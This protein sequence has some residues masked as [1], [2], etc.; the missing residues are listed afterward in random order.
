MK[1]LLL[2]LLAC[3]MFILV[4]GTASFAQQKIGHINTQE[5]LQLMPER[6]SAEKIFVKFNAE[7]TKNYESMNV[8]YN[9]LVETYTKQKDSLS[10]FIRSAK[11]AELVDMQTKIQNFQTVAQQELVKKQNELM[12]PI[13]TK[14]KNA[15]KAVAEANKFTYVIEAGGGVLGVLLYFPEDESLNLL[16]LVKAKL[17]IK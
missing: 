15:I 1:K 9:N 2:I 6:D 5:V 17:G 7:I 13:V 14:L 16:P 8:V 4:S 10:S 3:A 12:A 11:E